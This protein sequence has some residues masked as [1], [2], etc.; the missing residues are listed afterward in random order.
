MNARAG[1]SPTLVVERAGPLTLLEDIG[2]PGNG[3]IGVSPSG[4]L[5]PAA[6]RDANRLVGN[7]PDA[8]V[9]EI[10]LGD[11]RV[12]ATAPVWV[13]VV[14][15]VGPLERSDRAT[16]SR[17]A[18]LNSALLLEAGDTLT[19]GWAEYGV[20]YYLSVRGGFHA[21][22]V[23]GSRSF[24]LLSKIGPAPLSDG[25][26]LTV[27]ADDLA[28]A[29]LEPVPPID[30]LP[31]S[32]PTRDEVTMRVTEGPRLDWFAADAWSSLLAQS[33]QVTAE[34]N[35]VGV[36]LAGDPLGRVRDE[37]LPSEGVVTGA[38]QVPPSGQ[39]IIFLADHP[40]TGGYPVIG[41]VSRQDI[42]LAAQLRPGQRLRFV[43]SHL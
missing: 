27:G 36:R 29:T 14:G 32:A 12:R 5:D 40:T 24:D 26:I 30:W 31:V 18:A 34:A 1:E 37:E 4:A 6:L 38:L 25:D 43:P 21:P 10:L 8:A 7:P 28:D 35:R 42:R 2:R 19:I 41:V 3:A 22:R 15:A 17:P 23:L 16:G 11:L 20:R 33:W 39:P 13:A 9:L